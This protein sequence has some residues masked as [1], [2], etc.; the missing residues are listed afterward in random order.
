MIFYLLSIFFLIGAIFKKNIQI[1]FL[2]ISFIILFLISAY[3]GIT[4]GTDTIH[5]EFWFEQLS[6]GTEWIRNSIEP[7]W[8]WLNDFVIAIGGSYR[9]VLVLSSLLTLI[10]VFIVAKNNYNPML[11]ISFYYLFYFFFYSLNAIRQMIAV[12]L[13][14]FALNSLL[15]NRNIVFIVFT[16]FASLFHYSALFVIFLYFYKLVSDSKKILILFSIFSMIFGIFGVDI[17]AY[18]ASYT[19]YAFYFN[20]YEIGNIVGNAIYLLIFNSIFIFIVIASKNVSNE[21]K[22]YF[23]FILVLN[24]VLRLPMGTRLIWYFSIYQIIF[25]PYF[26]KYLISRN[27]DQAI[28]FVLFIVLFSYFI[29]YRSLGGGE[30]F[31]YVNILL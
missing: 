7:G 4:V 29:F 9:E 20:E 27:G 15:K 26:I 5:Y 6:L 28:I 13:I 31:P 11:V 21:L 23:I 25:Y 30:I 3:R 10:P 22:L 2:L 14:L 18:A 16:I 19:G 24:L 8:V 17:I 1:I 12:S